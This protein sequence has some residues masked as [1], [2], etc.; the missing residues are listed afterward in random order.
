M[1]PFFLLIFFLVVIPPSSYAQYE[2]RKGYAGFSIGASLPMGDF[3]NNPSEGA[4]AGF[5]KN[6]VALNL[7]FAYRI[8]SNFGLTAMVLI[9]SN[10]LDETGYLNA[11]NASTNLAGTNV[12]YTSVDADSWGMSGF[13]V[14]GFASIPLG[15]GGKVILEPRAVV[16]ILTAISPRI[17]VSYK[18][19][20]S[21]RW[22]ERQIGAGIG[23]G[24]GLG[25]SFRFNVSDRIA[26]LLNAD[27]LKTN[28][29]FIDVLINTSYGQ[30]FVTSFQQKIEVVN[31]TLGFAFRIK[32]DV[33]PVRKRFD[34]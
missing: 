11:L 6:G 18:E 10:S 22:E 12:R 4:S 9:Q 27:Y 26:L 23:F 25:G 17:K 7:N 3:S 33:P 19:G 32:K 15:T 2:S 34:S 31:V 8:A 29:K 28:P 21:N 24:Y 30:D 5:A 16:G 20:F 1:K 14:G 13:Q